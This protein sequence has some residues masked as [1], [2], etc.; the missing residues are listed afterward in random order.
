[1][2][3]LIGACTPALCALMLRV[4]SSLQ[5]CRASA[6]WAWNFLVDSLHCFILL[7]SWSTMFGL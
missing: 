4:L 3:A 5:S 7:S 2:R 1:M 6:L